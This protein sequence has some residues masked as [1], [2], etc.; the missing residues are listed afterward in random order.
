MEKK[1]ADENG[2]GNGQDMTD[3]ILN[4][5]PPA[6]KEEEI[7]FQE[8]DFCTETYLDLHGRALFEAH[9]HSMWRLSHECPL[10]DV[11]SKASSFFESLHDLSVSLPALAV[12]VGPSAFVKPGLCPSISH[13]DDLVFSLFEEEF[14]HTYVELFVCL[15]SCSIFFFFSSSLSLLFPASGFFIC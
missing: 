2:S 11:R 9:V 6:A 1:G 7:M 13:E 10:D 4:E 15:F 3:A 12:Y 14:M 5:L 8:V